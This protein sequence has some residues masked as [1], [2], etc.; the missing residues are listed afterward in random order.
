MGQYF[1]S[2]EMATLQ[3]NSD[4]NRVAQLVDYIPNEVYFVHNTDGSDVAT[5]DGKTRDL[6]FAT[7]D[8]A[9]NQCTA[10]KGDVI[11]LLPG[12][13]ES[14]SSASAATM[15]IAGV[16]VL[17]FGN[18]ADRPTIT[19]DTAVGASLV[20]SAASC[21]FKNVLF[22]GGVDA[23]TNPLSIQASD[24]LLKNCEYRDS[25][26]QAT[27][28][29]VATA[30]ADR[31]K[32]DGLVFRGSAAAGANSAIALTGCT[33]VEIINSD[34]DVDGDV[35]CIDCRTTAV[36]D[37][38]VNNC[39]LRNRHGDDICIMDTVTGSTGIMGPALDL[40]LE[41]DAANVTTA[42]TGA[43]FRVVGE[44]VTVGNAANQ[45]SLAINWTPV[46]DS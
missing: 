30:A 33:D 27:D 17:G 34:I 20:V 4:K 13:T 18:G 38:K 42:I 3:S 40:Q 31:M 10:S 19:F 32:I 43:T 39:K 2:A 29:I 5:R 8:Y 21:V 41:D 16:T 12:H 6:P 37:L 28:C 44:D 26:G 9:I 45:K 36:V 35:G 14:L 24:F 23:L 25:T 1:T 15:D 22:L 11:V 7:L 46:A